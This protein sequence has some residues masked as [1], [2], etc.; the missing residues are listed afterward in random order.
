M[1]SQL[2]KLYLTLA[3]LSAPPLSVHSK[4][5]DQPSPKPLAPEAAQMEPAAHGAAFMHH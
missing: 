3:P 4:V 2:A 5:P 1:V